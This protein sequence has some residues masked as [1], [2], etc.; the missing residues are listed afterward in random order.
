MKPFS[1]T[2]VGWTSS[3]ATVLAACSVILV[4][5]VISVIL[6]TM[7]VRYMRKHSTPALNKHVADQVGKQFRIYKY[8]FLQGYHSN[9]EKDRYHE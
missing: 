2:Y 1:D 7:F 6:M 9:N 8:T 5:F 3:E 4:I